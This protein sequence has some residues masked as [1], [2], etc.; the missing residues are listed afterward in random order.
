MKLRTRNY[1]FTTAET[2]PPALLGKGVG[3]L[4]KDATRRSGFTLLELLLASLIAAVLLGAY[5]LP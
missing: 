5:I 2:K 3:G 1:G 4:G